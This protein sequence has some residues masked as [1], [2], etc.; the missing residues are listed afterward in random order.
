MPAYSVNAPYPVFFDNLGALLEDGYVY[1][2]TVNL[3]PITNPITVYSDSA[4][5]TTV[6]QPIRTTLGEPVYAGSPTKLFVNAPNYSIMVKDKNGTTIFY[7]QDGKGVTIPMIKDVTY[8]G[9]KGDGVTDDTAAFQAADAAGAVYVMFEGT[10]A[11]ANNLTLSNPVTMYP[12]TILQVASTKTVTFNK[13]FNAPIGQCFS[14]S[15][16]IVFNKAYTSLGYPEWWGAVTGGPDCLAA[17]QACVAALPITQ[18][19]AA[20]YYLSAIWK[21]NT[22]SRV[23][24]GR[25]CFYNGV[26]GDSTRII[27]PNGS[28]TVIQVGPDSQ[29]ASIN[30]FTQGIVLQDFEVSR[31]AAPV[32]ASNCNGILV[33]YAL[34]PKL[35][36]IKSVESMRGFEWIGTVGGHYDDLWSFRS[37]AGT[38]GGTDYWYGFYINGTITIPASG[39]NASVYFNRCNATRSGGGGTIRYGFYINDKWAD[40]FVFQPEVNGCTTGILCAGNSSAVLGYGETDLHITNAIIDTYEFAGIHVQNLSKYGAVNINGGFAAANTA[41]TATA[42]I[43]IDTSLGNTTIANFQHIL[44]PATSVT[45]GLLCLN[46]N[47]V[48]STGCVYAESDDIPVLL[49]GCNNIRIDDRSTNYSKV[50]AAVVQMTNTTKSKLEMSAVGFGGGILLGYQLVST[51]NDYNELNCTGIDSSA[52][53][54]GSNNKLVENGVQITATGTF[55]TSNLASGVMT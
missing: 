6:A 8:Y 37:A 4:M 11:I 13:S 29:P 52:V 31:G 36:N 46:S 10:Y 17:L 51:G 9:A 45:G 18:L 28:T 49:S 42:S 39:G 26:T 3:N 2:G 32:I 20:D 22:P 44:G 12:K 21:I 7:A 43:Y 47:N 27:G 23:V 30:L 54:G 41:A 25:G 5:T 35:K 50:C 53:S 16:S 1:I 15:G 48:T 33:Q 38:G 55:G 24:Q 14:G 19:Q 34:Y 40:T